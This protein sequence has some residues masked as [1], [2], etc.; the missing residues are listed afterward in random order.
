MVL[1]P[2]E[3]QSALWMKLKSHLEEK[4]A[5]RRLQ[6]EGKLD[7][8]E[9]NRMRGRIAELKDCLKLDEVSPFPVA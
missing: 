8:D 3:I 6:L 9:T 7:P 5:A 4:L 2:N 1:A